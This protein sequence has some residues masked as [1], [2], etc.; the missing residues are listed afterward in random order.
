MNIKACL[1]ATL[2]LTPAITSADVH[3]HKATP[4]HSDIA[5]KGKA[6][7]AKLDA[8]DMKLVS[9]GKHV[10]DMKIAMG[11]LAKTNGTAPVKKYGTLLIKDH[12]SN[13][14][15]LAAMAKKKGI[16]KLAAEMPVTDPEKAEHQQMMD[17]M[18]KLKTMKGVDFD[19]EFLTMMVMEHDKEV[20]RFTEGAKMAKDKDVAMHL[21]ST[22]PVIQKHS[23]SARALQTKA[24][25]S[26][27]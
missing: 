27:R 21:A 26:M 14:T 20:Q 1:I 23:D 18:A 6:G 24:G 25:V 2:I 19:K 11:K 16:A 13:N 5:P 9:H 22:V 3:N 4:N 8:D 15:K 17:D 7:Q 10:N 12:T